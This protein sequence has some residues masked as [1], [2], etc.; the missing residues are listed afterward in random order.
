MQLPQI[1][2]EEH[3]KKLRNL[4]TD[5]ETHLRSLNSLG[6]STSSFGNFLVLVILN[7]GNWMSYSRVDRLRGD[8]C[9]YVCPQ[10]GFN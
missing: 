8:T 3:T 7:Y 5:V 4:L 10:S 6:I 9:S 1:T 2:H